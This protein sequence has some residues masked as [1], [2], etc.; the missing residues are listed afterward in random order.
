[1]DSHDILMFCENC[2]KARPM[3]FTDIEGPGG[4]R[5]PWMPG[6]NFTCA[7]CG[8]MSKHSS[9]PRLR[10]EGVPD[11]TPYRY[12]TLSCGGACRMVYHVYLVEEDYR[13]DGLVELLQKEN[14]EN[15]HPLGIPPWSED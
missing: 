10:T 9:R 3:V 12:Q 2:R 13:K 11:L 8:R 7:Q 4:R 14:C 1:M 6:G 15:G 5:I